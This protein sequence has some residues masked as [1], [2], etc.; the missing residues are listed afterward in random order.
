[1]VGVPYEDGDGAAQGDAVLKAGENFRGVS[2]LAR[3]HDFRLTWAAAVEFMLDLLER[4]GNARWATI[5]N[6]S[7]AAAMRLAKS[8][9][10]ENVAEGG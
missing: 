3:R 9:D 2:F 1:L 8:V 7:H 4:N 5:D 10:A 6:D